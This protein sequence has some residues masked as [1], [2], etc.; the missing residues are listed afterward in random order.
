MAYQ[1]EPTHVGR[2]P[3]LRLTLSSALAPLLGTAMV[4]ALA[5]VRSPLLE[6]EA[7]IVLGPTVE[8]ASPVAAAFG[9]AL[10]AAGRQDEFSLRIFG[11][12]AGTLVLAA[13][14]R[15]GNR[16]FS[17]RA[18]VF[19]ALVLPA[20]AAGRSILG[21]DLGVAPLEALA[22]LAALAAIRSF[23][24]TKRSRWHAVVAIGVTTALT[25]P[26]GLWL[27][28]MAGAWLW[29]LRGFNA[30][31]FLPLA[32]WSVGLWLG[33]EVLAVLIVAP[34]APLELASLMRS[35]PSGI[36]PDQLVA[37]ALALGVL[38][39]ALA[40][41][42]YVR[43]TDWL[44]RG[45][46]RFLG[47]WLGL[48]ALATLLG[49]SIVPL[50]LALSLVVGVILSWALMRARRSSLRPILVVTALGIVLLNLA[51][52]LDLG[53]RAD[54]DRWAVRE[55]A[56]FVRR[57][58]PAT[59]ELRVAAGAGDRVHWYSRRPV[60]PFAATARQ[61]AVPDKPS[62]A[63]VPRRSLTQDPEALRRPLPRTIEVGNQT[64]R[65]L[66]EFGPWAVLRSGTK[67]PPPRH[68][69][70]SS[71]VKPAPREGPA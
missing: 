8:H 35:T 17:N 11:I 61:A 14:I 65:V 68:P 25:G 20:T 16:L 23:G 56:R 22:T 70:P 39:P 13:L 28:A 6:R 46:P 44:S 43:P 31:S 42:V 55:A 33:L 54:L 49:G 5:P 10:L 59:S 45:S 24:T 40:L 32:A 7:A 53:R 47:A 34:G 52:R 51:P 48:A 12:L 60:V 1:L 62:Y 29:K 38:L 67:T 50:V 36:L 15:L 71:E 26:S 19:A 9:A 3:P 41:G 63:L 69:A 21:G 30:R 2:P 58:L 27:V 37:T 57:N 18:G 66:A 4:L 64:H